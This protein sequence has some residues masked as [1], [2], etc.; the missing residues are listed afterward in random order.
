MRIFVAG[1]TGVIGRRLVPRLVE[2]GH[3]VV[4]TTRTAGK[5]ELLEK[6]GAEPV[7]MDGLDRGSV[8]RAVIGAKPDVVIHQLTALTGASNLKKFDAEFELTNKLRVA[9]TDNLLAAARQ[10]GASRFI[11]Q[12]YTGWP[13]ARGGAAVKTEEDPLDPHPA[14]AARETLA[15]IRHIEATVPAAEWTR[16]DRAALRNL[17]WPRDGHR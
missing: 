3:A 1:A 8:L 4:G 14:A 10:A 5:L 12:S 9:G 2:A 7:V 11:A 15:A 6:A 16:R 17:L 13:N